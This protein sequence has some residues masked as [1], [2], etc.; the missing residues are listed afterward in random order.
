MTQPLYLLELNEINF[1]FVTH[2]VDSGRLPCLAQLIKRHGIATTFSESVYEHIEPWIQWV[3][4]HTGKTF[5]EHK[6]FRLGD[7]TSS[8][9][10]QIWE[11][12]EEHGV[13][14]GAVSPMNAVNRLRQPAFFIPDAWTS[15]SISA[16]ACTRALYRA[17]RQAVADNA[18]GRLAPASVF[19]LLAGFLRHVSPARWAAYF[20]LITRLRARPWVK[21]VF[22][23]ELLGDLFLS[24]VKEHRPQ[25][26]TLF[27][28][29]GAHIQH[30]Y[31][32]SSKA[33][34]GSRKNP[35]WYVAG[36]EDPLLE[37]YEAYDELLRRIIAAHP[38]A[39]ILI[40][41]GLHQDPYPKET[42]YWRLRDHAQF[43][44]SVGCKFES[45]EPLMSR[46]FVIRFPG[47][48]EAE[49]A[50]ALLNGARLSSDNRPVFSADNRGQ[51]AFCTLTYDR[52]IAHTDEILINAKRVGFRDQVSFVAIKNAHH[53]GI[54]YLIDTVEARSPAPLPVTQLF[55]SVVDH[56][57]ARAEA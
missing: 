11:V 52:D 1:D 40:A 20:R 30:H 22:M 7:I 43:L 42:F 48:R 6:I 33:Y 31:L 32:F 45:V 2:Y 8:N 29:A 10:R 49:A 24:L 39:R 21:A 34:R 13:K 23:D 36:E 50:T 9:V 53:S 38:S 17:I 4:A 54:G 51:S 56:F 14:V 27:L 26:A 37:I 19:G 12:L 57:G 47:L 18:N 41:T 5:A 44:T 3:S 16:D 46:D 35:V 28:N 55:D 15:S 25:F